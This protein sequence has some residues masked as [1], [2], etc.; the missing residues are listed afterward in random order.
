MLISNLIFLKKYYFNVF[1]IKKYFE[2]Q[3]ATTLSKSVF[4]I[5][6]AVVVVV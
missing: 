3:P 1:S 4:G 5:V 2:N 6:V